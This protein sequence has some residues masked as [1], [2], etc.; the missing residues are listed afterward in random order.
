MYPSV[1]ILAESSSDSNSVSH[2]TT[3][4][5]IRPRTDTHHEINGRQCQSITRHLGCSRWV[6]GRRCT[7]TSVSFRRHSRRE[8]LGFKLSQ[9]SD[10]GLSYKTKNRYTSWNQWQTM[11]IHRQASWLY[12]RVGGRSGTVVGGSSRRRSRRELLGFKLSQS[13][14]RHLG[15]TVEWAVGAVPSSVDPSVVILAE[16]SSDS[17]SVSQPTTDSAIMPI[18][19]THHGINGRQCQS[20]AKHRGCSCWVGGRSGTVVDGPSVVILAESS[21]DSNSVSQPTTDSAIR[22]RTDT[23]HEING[24]QCQSIT[25]HLGCSR[26][27]GG[28]RCTVTSV[29][30][31]RHSRRELLGFKLSQPPDHGLSYKTKNRYTPWNQWQTM[32]IHRQAS[33]LYGRV[34]GRSGTVVG[35]SFRRHSR[36]ELLGFKLSQPTDHGL[37]YNANNRYT[38]WNQWQTM[39]IHRQASW[40]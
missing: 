26:W 5:A 23:H 27:V 13:I 31:R 32:P 38:P 7:V 24:R 30:F 10:H 4:S 29:S 40:L 15:C 12:G 9:P 6:G 3:D 21:S 20:I 36:R 2:P 16:S 14:A 17:N 39:P 33:W 28:R 34:G 22:P 35:G 25:R 11:P 19:D 8:L 18:I 1:V 37:S